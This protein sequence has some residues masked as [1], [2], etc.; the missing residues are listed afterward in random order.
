[1]YMFLTGVGDSGIEMDLEPLSE[2]CISPKALVTHD[3]HSY[4]QHITHEVTRP[5]HTLQPY[6]IPTLQTHSPHH[7]SMCTIKV[8]ILNGAAVVL[9]VPSLR[10]SAT[11]KVTLA[12]NIK[13]KLAEVRTL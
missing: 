3:N 8:R 11:Q 9:Q 4:M 2:M 1:M 7:V 13:H 12:A 6:P 5:F 10:S